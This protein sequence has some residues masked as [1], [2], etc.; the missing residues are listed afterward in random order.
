MNQHSARGAGLRLLVAYA[1]PDDEAF[2]AG[3]TIAL[4]AEQG[5]EVIL[6]VA[7]GGEEGEIVNPEM[8][9]LVALEDLPTVRQDELA[10][11]AAA[12]GIARVIRL[13]YHDSG[14]AG[15]PSSKQPKAFSRQADD[16][17][18][19]RMVEIIR[20]VRPHVIITEPEDGGY[21][22]PDHIALH[23]ATVQAFRDAGDRTLYRE[24]GEPWSAGK[25]YFA[26]WSKKLFGQLK[27]GYTAHGLT[28]QFGT[29]M[30]IIDEADAPGRPDED[31][32]AVVDISS[33]IHR[34]IKALRCYRTQIMNDFFFFTAP[35]D[36]LTGVLSKE[37]FMLG[38]STVEVTLPE[39]DLFTGINP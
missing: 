27:A 16:D 12:L 19:R 33:T 11:S 32:A 7:T 1:H 37:Y 14:M 25:L 9:D 34:K 29:G 10:C 36:V 24:T 22:H 2:T 30:V 13:G 39:S 31:I 21:G 28:F 35:E 3:G 20:E 18:V 5:V 4:S 23:H 26:T 17:V 15:T 6:A 8:R 38:A